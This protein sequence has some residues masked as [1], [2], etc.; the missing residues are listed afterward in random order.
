M[1]SVACAAAYVDLEVDGVTI[2]PQSV[3]LVTETG[4]EGAGAEFMGQI[5]SNAYTDSV[6]VSGAQEFAVKREQ[7][8]RPWYNAYVSPAKQLLDQL[9]GKNVKVANDAGEKSGT[10]KWVTESWLGITG[11]GGFIAMPVGTIQSVEGPGSLSAPNET[12]ESKDQVNVTWLSSGGKQ[13]KVTYLSSGLSWTPTYFLDAADASSRIEFWASVEN[14]LE[15]I[16]A[17]VKLIAGNVN[18]VSSSYNSRYKYADYDMAMEAAPAPSGGY[19]GSAPE[20]SSLGEYEVYDLGKRAITKNEARL[21]SVFQGNV[22]P[23]KEYLWQTSYGDSVQR[24]YKIENSG[25]TWPQG[26]VK[27]FEGGIMVGEDYMDWTPKGEKAEITIGKAPD[28]DVSKDTTTEETG[29]ILRDT[30]SHTTTLKLENR[31]AEPVT[32]HIVDYYPYVIEG[33]FQ[34]SD[35]WVMK[36]GN[37]MELNVTI[38]ANGEK[39]L[40]YKYRT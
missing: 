1:A 24:V 7:S 2:Y 22:K 18:I 21:L 26:K 8:Y 10:L 36:P 33:T 38:S 9:V 34:A 13:V 4:N 29:A 25:K 31:K 11:A 5:N 3:G 35:K 15:D 16:N 17:S 37:I 14:S 27:V 12:Q 30:R 20:V 6:R 39:E 19:M 32:V 23:E 28:I 40:T